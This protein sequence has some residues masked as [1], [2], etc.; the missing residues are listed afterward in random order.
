MTQLPVVPNWFTV[1]QVSPTLTLIR[2]PHTKPV[3]AANTWVIHGRDRDLFVDSGLGIASMRSC[4]PEFFD[5]E[6]A[7]VA[8]HG[9]L[10]HL[11]GAHEFAEVWAHA[12]ER[13]ERPGRGSLVPGSL[14]HVLGA[15]D[16][17]FG[18]GVL[19]DA[20]PEESYDW[21]AY[22]LRPVVPTREL[23]EGDVI[24][25]GDARWE[26]LHLPGHTPG[27]VAI[28]EPEQKLLFSGDVVYDDGTDMIDFLA[29]SSPEDY[30][31][32]MRRLLELDVDTIMAGHGERFGRERLVELAE[33]YL[34]RVGKPKTYA[35]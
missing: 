33:R 30:Q 21:G 19:L 14:A 9:H 2:E 23:A 22:E 12:A 1:E 35:G 8:T 32:T 7:L 16:G 18:D 11:G 3:L 20:V 26:V 6:P 24:D 15:P 13:I 29:E 5:R 17:I 27:S 10:D 28:F 4:I 34:C 31:V 25:L